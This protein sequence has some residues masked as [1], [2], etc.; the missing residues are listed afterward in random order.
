MT[1]S[2]PPR[3]AAQFHS[4]V[5][6]VREWPEYAAG[7]IEG[8]LLVPLGTL[9]REVRD[10]D[11]RKPVLLVCRSG[12]RAERA[13]VTLDQLGFE[14]VNILSGGIDAWRAQGLPLQASSKKPISLERQV[15][16]IAGAL[17]LGFTVLALIVSPWFLAGTL[18]IGAGLLFAGVT[19]LCL[20][21]ALLGKLPWN[22]AA[23]F[24]CSAGSQRLF[25]K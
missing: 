22:R 25:E 23:D 7:A 4:L 12:R 9:A 14:D 19:D 24:G 8:S 2:I 16:A 17:V 1:R 5:V 11:R 18:F 20:M 6:D 3:E 10:W 13:A 21:A 15:R